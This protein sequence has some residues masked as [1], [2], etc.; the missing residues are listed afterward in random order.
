MSKK[1]RT[2]SLKLS[3]SI[4]WLAVP[5]FVLSLSVFYNHMN[6]M[7]RHEA[8]ERSSTILNT[9]V[10]R[11]ENYI[12]VIETAARSNLWMLETYFTP[13][14]LQQISHRIV[15]LNPDV[16]SCSVSTEPDVFPE[17]G[18][19]FSVYSVDE[20]DTVITTVEPD[21]E[22][23]DK[24]WYRTAVQSGRPC[25]VE[26]FVDF[27]SGT[28]NYRDAVA[29]YCVPIRPKGGK[30]A[31]VVSTDFSFRHLAETILETEHPYPSSY[32]MLIG[33]GGRYLIH[34]ETDLLFKKSVFTKFEAEENPDIIAMGHEMTEG[35]TGTMHVTIRGEKCHV[36]YAPVSGTKW[37]LALISP[38]DEVLADYNHLVV[39]MVLVVIAGLILI[40]WITNRVVKK[41]IEPI[42]KLLDA[43]KQMADGNYNVYIP[44][45]TRK[46][47]VSKL[48][49]AF[50]DMQQA[51]IAHTNTITETSE[52]VD[53]ETEELEQVLPKAQEAHRRKLL[54]IQNVSHQIGAPL[55]VINGLAS[56]LQ[57]NISTGS[58]EGTTEE[59][60]EFH[61]ISETMKHNAIMLHRSMLMLFDSSDARLADKDRYRTND[62][63]AC[64]D[65]VRDCINHTL[66]IYPNAEIVLESELPDTMKIKTN[67]LYLT[68]TIRELLHNAV[69]HTDGKDIKVRITQTTDYVQFIIEDKGPG[70]PEDIHEHIFVPFMKGDNLQKGLGLGLPLCKGHATSLDGKFYVDENYHDGCRFI[71]EMPK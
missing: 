47:H 29:S 27:N 62:V 4:M 17:V 23:F 11:V 6:H 33:E 34:P 37:S 48:Q 44:T 32:Y 28:I 13:D 19:Y 59:R 70:L 22:Y 60:E 25:W 3:R 30:I 58:Q 61:K 53:K 67:H 24:V 68:R 31:G 39:V 38:E 7:I 8:A 12:S 1:R 15:E 66:T 54:F 36:C 21:F 9:T 64:N 16:L 57:N 63:V 10:Q 46:D 18:H 50:H 42:N 65:L 49:N 56:V 5:I 14:S 2:L 20:G 71:L 41:N 55:N 45:T 35:K 69:K 43:T 51:I 40:R 52:E 26:P